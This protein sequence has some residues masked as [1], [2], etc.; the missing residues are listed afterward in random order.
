MSNQAL[1]NFNNT[2]SDVGGLEELARGIDTSEVFVNN[3]S[4]MLGIL[5][6]VMVLAI[7]F[8]M[9]HTYQLEERQALAEAERN[10][11]QAEK[12]KIQ[13]ME[14]YRNTM[15]NIIERYVIHLTN[16]TSRSSVLSTSKHVAVDLGA[17]G[18]NCSH[19]NLKTRQIPSGN[20]DDEV[21]IETITLS[22]DSSAEDVEGSIDSI[23]DND[24]GFIISGVEI[25]T[26]STPILPTHTIGIS[27]QIQ[28]QMQI[29]E[30]PP[31]P[32][33]SS[34]T[35]TITHANLREA[36]TDNPCSI[37]LEPFRAGDDI[38]CCSNNITGKKPH[39][40]HRA[41]SLDYIVTHTDG[42]NAPCPCCRRLLLPS[43]A[44]YK[45]CFKC[46]H[47]SAL[48]LPELGESNEDDNF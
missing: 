8:Y 33:S 34:T 15:S 25:E 44:E 37:C 7:F 11:I 35:S 30:A 13:D 39:V 21:P 22:G 43:E 32:P 20:E 26:A 1:D 5:F 29:D 9:S 46:S 3:G 48:T 24:N 19:H 16:I 40:F 14:S 41:C 2:I 38:V 47:S 45:G 36:V 17:P 28:I 31:L 18:K 27:S 10:R 23:D 6:C 12:E 42:I 4:S